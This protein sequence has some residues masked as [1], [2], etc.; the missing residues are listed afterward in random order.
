[1]TKVN[2]MPGIRVQIRL[3]GEMK[4]QYILCNRFLALTDAAVFNL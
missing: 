3:G 1:M 4:K 2:R